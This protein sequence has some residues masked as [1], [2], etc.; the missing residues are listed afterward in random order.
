MIAREIAVTTDRPID[1]H[2]VLHRLQASFGS[3]YRFAVDGLIGAS[4]ELLVEVYGQV[5]RSHPLAGTAPAPA[6]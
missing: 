4:P 6:T 2:G 3:S 5:V 1:R